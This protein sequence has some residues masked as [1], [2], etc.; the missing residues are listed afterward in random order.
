[1]WALLCAPATLGAGCWEVRGGMRGLGSP[2][3]IGTKKTR[4]KY[5]EARANYMKPKGSRHTWKR[6][7]QLEKQWPKG[8][9]SGDM[10]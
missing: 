3:G 6:T 4:S 10:D 5:A 1:M 9:Q 8:T 7:T 2:L